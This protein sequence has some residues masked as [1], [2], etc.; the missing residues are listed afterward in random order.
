MTDA[1]TIL[2]NTEFSEP[3]GEIMAVN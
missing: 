3:I 1:Y 2:Q